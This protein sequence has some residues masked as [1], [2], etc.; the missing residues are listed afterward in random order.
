M[1][2]CGIAKVWFINPAFVWMQWRLVATFFIFIF[3][4]LL[5]LTYA[6]AI[7]LDKYGTESAE[8]IG[9]VVTHPRD[10]DTSPCK[11]YSSFNF[12]LQFAVSVID[13]GM[14]IAFCYVAFFSLP[15]FAQWWQTLLCTGTVLGVNE[16]IRS[17]QP[18]TL[19]PKKTD[20][21]NGI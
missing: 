4:V 12:G 6:I 19:T 9:C 8:Y 1:I 3:T 14:P 10:P 2:F 17:T 18:P 11:Q 13:A 15:W 7:D 16:S 5:S 20:S 21:E